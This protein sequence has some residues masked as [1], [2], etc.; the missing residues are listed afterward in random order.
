M[1]L[2]PLP[3]EPEL[4]QKVA[5][6]CTVSF[7]KLFYGYVGQLSGFVQTLTHSTALTEEIVQEVFT[8][9]WIKREGLIAVQRFDSYLFILTRNHTLTVIRKAN[10][11]RIQLEG[12]KYEMEELEL[13]KAFKEP[14]PDNELLI[15]CAI[16]LLPQRQQQVF[17]LR[18]EG[19][20][21]P[22]IAL[23]LD[24]SNPSVIKYQ[25]LALKA[26][27][28]FAKMRNINLMFWLLFLVA[29]LAI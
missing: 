21:N 29:M 5:S 14:E 26:L 12:F 18:R 23:K 22:E 15:E 4:L 28:K 3:N 24:I 1:A 10:K 13:P 6:G 7:T 20:K 9:I 19:F 2:T 25:Q 8:K 17:A 27:S 16:A 11:E